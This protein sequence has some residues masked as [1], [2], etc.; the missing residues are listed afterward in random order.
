[1]AKLSDAELAAN[2]RRG[3]QRRSERLRERQAAAG[4]RQLV[5]W[6]TTTTRAALEL[7]AASRGL[8]VG[9]TAAALLAEALNSHTPAER[10]AAVTA[11]AQ[12]RDAD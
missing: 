12:A 9:Q 1:M 3:N 2:I 11:A 5:T 6:I 8:P 10:L 4:K 7:E